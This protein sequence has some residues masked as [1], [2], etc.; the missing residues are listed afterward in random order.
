MVLIEREKEFETTLLK[1]H[2]YA[3]G[4][5]LSEIEMQE[6]IHSLK[7]IFSEWG[8]LFASRDLSLNLNN[9]FGNFT[10]KEASELDFLISPFEHYAIALEEFKRRS[11]RDCTTRCGM[12]VERFVNLFWPLFC[13]YPRPKIED[14]IGALQSEI[15][16]RK[17]SLDGGAVQNNCQLMKHIYS[18]RNKRGP[19]DVPAAIEGEAKFCINTIPEV[20]FSYCDVLGALKISLPP[21]KEFFS[22]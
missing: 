22:S 2:E 15:T 16:A 14:A 10:Q 9:A 1:L 21:Q 6:L 12:V 18:K 3:N 17:I 13:S 8:K 11:Y 20:Y 19:H 4:S 5:K 7:S